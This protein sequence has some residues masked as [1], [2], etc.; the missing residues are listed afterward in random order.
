MASLTR[1]DICTALQDLLQDDTDNLYGPSKLINYISVKYVEWEKAKVHIDKP[2]KM[3]IKAP[4]KDKV[5]VRM[6][7]NADYSIVAT[8]RIEGLASDPQ[9]AY[10]RIDDIDERINYLCD[11]EMHSGN[12][13]STHFNN[14]ECT[15]T[16]IEW[17]G[18]DCDTRKDEGGWKVECEG[19]IR[20]EINRINP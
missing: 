4:R 15:V 1:L 16:N 14:T 7:N 18:S 19:T 8:Y 11:Y 3:Y 20:I 17:E 2:Y 12:N 13:L 5:N 9:T 10:E 6:G